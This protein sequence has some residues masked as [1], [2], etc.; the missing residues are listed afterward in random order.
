MSTVLGP[1]SQNF[2]GKAEEDFLSK[3]N[4]GKIFGNAL[5]SN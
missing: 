3:E 1:H 5:I 4:H 2:L